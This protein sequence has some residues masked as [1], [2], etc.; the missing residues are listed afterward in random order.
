MWHRV[1]G[2]FLCAAPLAAMLIGCQDRAAPGSPGAATG[3]AAP[4][5]FDES[6]G[7]LHKPSGVGFVYPDGWENLGVTDRGPITSLGLRKREPQI[8]V[9]LYWTR[10]DEP[11]DAMTVGEVEYETLRSVY[12]D[13]VGTPEPIRSGDQFGYRLMISR[14]PLGQENP[15]LSGVV[16]VFAV[17]RDSQPW[18][19]K[20]RATAAGREHLATAEELLRNYHW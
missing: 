13:K 20:L 2:W 12:G 1:V 9:T 8:E 4:A 10:P 16:Y 3:V 11:I 18:K 7:Y 15:N 19:I 14:G 17:H 5:A 6:K